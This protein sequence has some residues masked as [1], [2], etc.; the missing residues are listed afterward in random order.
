MFLMEM[1]PLRC[2]KSVPIASREILLCV[3]DIESID[4]SASGIN[5][6]TWIVYGAI[7]PSN[8]VSGN[9]PTTCC[10]DVMFCEV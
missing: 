7:T 4:G 8:A 3:R 5:R 6:V 10:L 2:T 1:Y 9:L